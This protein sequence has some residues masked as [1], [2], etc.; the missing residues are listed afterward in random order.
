MN[1][2]AASDAALGFRPSA[3]PPL[4]PSIN[5][6]VSPPILARYRQTASASGIAPERQPAVPARG[7]PTASLPGDAAV[8]A[9]MDSVS[10]GAGVMAPASGNNGVPPTAVIMFPGDGTVL[11]AAAKNQIKQ[12]AARYRDAGG[13]GSIRVVGHASS[14]TA[15]M[16]VEKHLELI[17]EKSQERANA[18]GQELIRDGIPADRVLIEA[19]G[20]S[21]P[22]YYESMPQGEEGNRRAEIFLQT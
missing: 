14:R 17:F 4:D 12:A 13:T 3:A 1:A 7:A 21:Q 2:Q 5:Q 19:V 15:N 18:V 11:S 9:N 6:W 20:D 22:V 8:V 16:P 10:A